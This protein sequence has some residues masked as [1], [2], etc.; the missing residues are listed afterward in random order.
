MP[1]IGTEVVRTVTKYLI[2]VKEQN[3]RP[4]TSHPPPKKLK[5]YIKFICDECF[6]IVVIRRLEL[7]RAA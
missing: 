4:P 2:P 7:T 3:L 1:E 5:E 6:V